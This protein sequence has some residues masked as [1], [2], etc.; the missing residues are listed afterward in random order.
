MKTNPRAT[1]RLLT[2]IIVLLLAV[3]DPVSARIT[4]GPSYSQTAWQNGYLTPQ[5]DPSLVQTGQYRYYVD[6]VNG[7]NVTGNGTSVAPWQTISYAMGQIMGTDVE[8]HVAPGVYDAALGESFPVVM[9]P[10]ISLIGAGYTQTIIAG[11]GSDSVIRFPASSIYTETTVLQ[12][13]K[14]TD[15][16]QGVRLDGFTG[17]GSSPLIQD[18]WI[19]GNTYGIYVDTASSRKVYALIRDNL[20][21]NNSSHG[22][23]SRA[24]YT[25]AHASPTIEKNQ[26][27]NN[28]GDGIYCWAGA[29][30]GET[31]Y[32]SP[33]IRQNLIQ[34]NAGVGIRCVTYYAGN[35]GLQIVGNTI[36]R[37]AGWG[38]SRSHS[39]TYLVTS[40]PYLASN[41][42]YGHS[43]GGASFYSS[44]TPLLVNN[45]LV[46]NNTYG[47]LGSQATVVNSIVWGHG[48]DLNTSLAKVSYSDVSEA[49]YEGW[50][51]TLSIDPQFV[52]PAQNDYHLQLTSPL[53]GAGDSSHP[54][55]PIIDVD[56]APRLVGTAVDIGADE[57]APQYHLAI[58]QT[59]VPDTIAPGEM[60]TYT[61]TITNLA[62]TPAV[63]VAITDQLPV[64]MSWGGYASASTGQV[65]AAQNEMSW[66]GDLP[67]LEPG[68]I[69][70]NAVLNAD[71]PTR[72]AIP[73]TAF[74]LPWGGLVTE[75]LP[76]TVTT[77]SGPVW[78]L[79]SQTV[80]QEYAGSGD[81]L[82]YTL[83][84]RNSGDAAAVNME[85]RDRLD[86]N[87]TFVLA[88]D[89]GSFAGGEVT[90]SVPTL[91][92]GEVIT[93]SLVL[94]VNE[95]VPNGTIVVNNVRVT[96]QSGYFFDLST[97]AATTFIRNPG[98][99]IS[100]YTLADDV[101]DDGECTLR[102]AIIAANTDTGSG[103]LPGECPAGNGDDVIDLTPLNGTILLTAPLPDISTN[104]VLQGPGQTTLTLDG[105]GKYRVFKISGGDVTIS[106][107]TIANGYVGPSDGHGGGILNQSP[108][109]VI[110]QDSILSN[111]RAVG[112]NGTN[113]YSGGQTG[114]CF[115]GG[116]GIFH[117]GPG[118]LD[119]L[120]TT[121]SNNTAVGGS[122]GG[123]T[124]GTGGGGGG[125]AFGG[126]LFANG[127]T[128]NVL[129]STF[130]NNYVYGGYG[131]NT[132]GGSSPY[133]G[134]GGGGQ[135]NGLGA[136]GKGGGNGSAGD[137]GNFGG[138]GGGGSWTG[139]G[140]L[141]GLGGGNGGNGNAGGG[142][143]AG[144]LGAAIFVNG[145]Q[146]TVSNTAFTGN[147][148]YAGLGG[149]G[150][151]YG[152][153]GQGLGYAIFNR[154]VTNLEDNLIPNTA[155]V[156]SGYLP[157]NGTA[158]VSV[159]AALS[160]NAV[161]PDATKYLYG[162]GAMRV[163]L[164][165][166]TD[167]N[168]LIEVTPAGSTFQP[169]EPF[170]YLTN[171]YWVITATDELSTTSSG[172]M[173]FTTQPK[174]S[175]D[176]YDP[177]LGATRVPL[178]QLLGWDATD[179]AG[180][181][182]TY[183]LAFGPAPETL[184]EMHSVTP[185][186][187]PPLE[188]KYNTTYYWVITAT[189][190]AIITSTGLLSFTT[191]GNEA[192]VFESYTPAPGTVDVPLSQTLNWTTTDGDADPI[193][194]QV[195]FGDSPDTLVEINSTH[196]LPPIAPPTPLEYATTYYWVI[197]ATDGISLTTSGL[198]SFT[199]VA[200]TPPILSNFTPAN[201]TAGVPVDQMLD[202]D[203]FDADGHPIHYAVAL[204]TD[205]AALVETSDVSPPFDPGT[206]SYATTYYWVVT[207][208]DSLSATST[209]GILSFT[210][211][212]LYAA[213]C[214]FSDGFESGLLSEYWT[215]DITNEGRVSVSTTYPRTGSYSVLLDDS[216]P[217]GQFSQAA[218][219]LTV[220]LT[221][222]TAPHRL[223]FWWH[224]FD[225][226]NDPGDGVF[227]SH[228]GLTWHQVFSF[229]NGPATF[230]EDMINLK[231][232]AVAH[233]LS[234]DTPLKVK[235]QFYDDYPIFSDG[236]V[237][238]DVSIDCTTNAVPT[239][240]NF[241]PVPNATDVPLN[242]SLSWDGDDPD[243]DPLT[244]NVAFGSNP[245]SLIETSGLT[246]STFSPPALE[247][248]TTY[249]WII[250]ATD[251]LSSASSGLLNFTTTAAPNRAPQISLTA[252]LSGTINV[253]ISPTLQ[254]AGLDA[255]GNPLTYTVAL[256]IVNPPLALV[257][258]D[259]TTTGYQVGP[260][261]HKTTYYWQVTATDGVSQSISPVWMFMTAPPC[262]PVTG[263]VLT[264]QPQGNLFVGTP[265]RFRANADGTKPLTHSWMVNDTPA[266][267]I[268]NILDTIFSAPGLYVVTV[269]ISNACTPVPVSKSVVVEIQQ[270]K[271]DQP[272]LSASSLVANRARVRKD[273]ILT[274]TIVLRN[275]SLTVADQASVTGAIPAPYTQYIPGSASASD[276]TPVT[277]NGSLVMWQGQVIS[278]TPVVIEYAVKVLEAPTG[279]EIV[280][281]VAIDDGFGATVQLQTQS[282]YDPLF[283][284]SINHGDIYTNLPTVTL[285]LSW[286]ATNPPINTVLLSNDGGFGPGSQQQPA[287][288]HV[289]WVLST[290]GNI[291]IPRTVYAIF[292]ASDGS[293]YGPLQ[294]EIVYDPT[295]PAVEVQLIKP[296]TLGQPAAQDI[297]AI[298]RVISRD[299]NSGVE[300]VVMSDDPDFASPATVTYAVTASSQDFAW[301]WPGDVYVKVIDRAGNV[302]AVKQASFNLDHFNTYLPVIIK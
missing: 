299:D 42:I 225:D 39:G 230:R 103:S 200:N 254:W 180:D 45:T 222:S 131:G 84:I 22:I 106:G 111:N 127:G 172:L 265:V 126:G 117:N 171:Y 195:A 57:E 279:Q 94:A 259:L 236:Y 193:E 188:L 60:I 208:T 109:L 204:G 6:A 242:V 262:E 58:V 178:D 101:V 13:F 264:Y 274:Y 214:G 85:I 104:M 219:I 215:S 278:G 296:T 293:D 192:P 199:T 91:A 11:N 77:R 175:I 27:L 271:V 43:T 268:T 160:W 231:A 147:W 197:T 267:S 66:H 149:S 158:N 120:M 5:L 191:R 165:Y 185:P 142:G 173:R 133:P 194:F 138:G 241:S 182:L 146:V 190:G 174:I 186:T 69:I 300:W 124:N 187:I 196:P 243:G 166:G 108:G 295:V 289:D 257:G 8:L 263:A 87:T 203:G 130:L 220:D 129:S 99:T 210:T 179:A 301:S 159:N 169:P 83:Q 161:D 184:I 3:V 121:F 49:S 216:T 168:N 72:L 59:V 205:P 151:S 35:C 298:V 12:G 18:N 41:L 232:E 285:T 75:T 294:D 248:L 122:G 249:Y 207:A 132:V 286:G 234:L 211:Q 80:N 26:I 276:G 270:K 44:D 95:A 33:Q 51:H 113:S 105:G 20:I 164:G 128:T 92:I 252:P 238:D 15:G 47:V 46:N 36:A 1:L 275:Q 55:L 98:R 54:S 223:H 273:D 198:L 201:G 280:N 17:S 247:R 170:D 56:G 137:N 53:V 233:G 260:L 10:E 139:T 148:A 50:Q 235:F 19:T 125:G 21:A 156:L 292:F 239:L 221:D 228:D 4:A 118:R 116:G 31:S 224:E 253:D 150:S 107:L 177:P 245:A 157:A 255:D 183:T 90:W 256:D 251:G 141:G 288:E 112:A 167:P 181:P 143:G 114:C 96:D 102:E 7:S 24:D 144:G 244:Y 176:A 62:G 32:C 79:S 136:G 272:D 76:V 64:E 52:D 89:G 277:V 40:S 14:I 82:T 78:S 28:G 284:L 135:V 227:I 48:D 67:P 226:E 291:V 287:R 246:T 65:E 297:T 9:K 266:D 269:N 68:T 73:N 2:G 123:G 115:G 97:E 154:S 145:G 23:Y 218:I 81:L 282:V 86:S 34:D 93:R 38:F 71:L 119:V 206:L 152:G 213:G 217:G 237:I 37:N 74:L 189:D 153:N 29:S 70:Y 281:T 100:V 30:S 63:D 134:G 162:F 25:R 240:A 61:V 258:T 229:N 250:T 163:T 302:S 140:G 155:P 209:S 261:A 283:G 16:A 202:W 290:Y 88:S 212:A 110:V